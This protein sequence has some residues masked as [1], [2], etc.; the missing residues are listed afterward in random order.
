MK[1][2]DAIGLG[3]SLCVHV[4]AVVLLAL[5]VTAAQKPKE[6]EQIGFIAIEYGPII[7]GRPVQ[8][9]EPAR[10]PVE[11]PK[12]EPRESAPR[13][14]EPAETSKPVELPKQ[15][16]VDPEKIE[17]PTT[18]KVAPSEQIAPAKSDEAEEESESRSD[19]VTAGVADGTS[20]AE[21]GTQ[22]EGSDEKK[23]SPFNIEGLNRRALSAPVPRYVE[24][25]NAT[26]KMRITVD[27]SGRVIQAFPLVKGNSPALEQASIRALLQWRFN[28]LP[29]NAPQENQTGAVT[30]YFR[31][32]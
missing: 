10:K 12:V 16:V 7:E 5:F 23:S 19:D 2:N 1:K 32:D 11:K 24:K 31:L 9:G 21:T 26:I 14:A 20:G 29:A 27:P 3:V 30:F 17:A 4:V 13:R 25:V 28:P 22:G 15:P 18:E 6:P 8:R